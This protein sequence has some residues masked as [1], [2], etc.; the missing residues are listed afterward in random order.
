MIFLFFFGLLFQI[1]RIK[2]R[3]VNPDIKEQ[4]LLKGLAVSDKKAIETIY[5]ENYNMVQSLIINNDGTI[6]EA[7]D[8]FQEAMIILF[9]KARSGNFELTSQIKTYVYSVCRR[10]WLKRLQQL[11][12]YSVEME[13]VAEVVP[14]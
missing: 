8:V 14:V 6:H 3:R 2:N 12:R 13:S 4:E 9:E 10:I 5:K 7:K 11:N 1:N